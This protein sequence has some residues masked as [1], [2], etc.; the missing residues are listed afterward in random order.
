MSDGHVTNMCGWFVSNFDDFLDSAGVDL[1]AVGGGW[2]EKEEKTDE[3]GA[4]LA[5]I[6]ITQL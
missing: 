4:V 3:R 6:V 1:A 5:L 2:K